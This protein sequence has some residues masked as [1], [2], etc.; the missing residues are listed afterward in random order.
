MTLV[1]VCGRESFRAEARWQRVCAVCGTAGG[2]HPHHVVTEGELR[3]RCGLRGRE[4]YNTLNALRVCVRCHERHHSPGRMR[5]IKTIE[6]KTANVVYAF[7]MLGLRAVS[8]LRR[9]YDDRE[10]DPRILELESR[11]EHAA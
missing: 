8:Y 3:R 5:L 1:G 7:Q 10:S 9:Y 4:L 11:Y 2:F 6:L